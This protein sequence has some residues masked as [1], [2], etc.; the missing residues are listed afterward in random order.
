MLVLMAVMW[1]VNFAAV[2]GALA[3]LDVLAFSAL[4]FALAATVL[5]GVVL[6]R[7]ER[8]RIPRAEWLPVIALGLVGHTAYQVLFATGLSRTSTSHSSLILALVPV[9]VAVIGTVLRFERM[10]AAAW[11]G[12]ILSL[13][14]I[15]LVIAGSD[16]SGQA[17]AAGDLL[18]MGAM[19]AW[20]LY[21]VFGS[22]LLERHS[23]LVLT[24]ATMCV[25]ALGLGVLGAPSLVAQD[26]GA[27]SAEAWALL[28]YSALGGLVAAYVI[29]YMGV[30]A[31]GSART[32]AYS[33]LVPV[34][35]LVVGWLFL[36]EMLS[37][38]QWAGAAAALFGV[39]MTRRARLQGSTT[40]DIMGGVEI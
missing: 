30:R 3:D 15:G 33:N 14:G 26:W 20:S 13:A 5:L 8:I 24:T 10:G 16:P 7:G 29:W 2:K 35:A 6:A 39:W 37:P 17:S 34:V 4:R 27:V 19:L 25:G 28:L 40:S 22:P 1:G 23:P 11:A 36:G 32:A 38:V 12:T 18:T 21:T 31:I 9:T